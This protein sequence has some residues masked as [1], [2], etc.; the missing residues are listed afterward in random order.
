MDHY[1]LAQI[2]IEDENKYQKYIEKSEE[3]FNRYNGEYLA[4]DDHPI[5][6]EGTKQYYRTVLIKFKSKDDFFEWYHSNEYK[7]ILEYRLS[8]AH[9]NS[10]LIKG[11]NKK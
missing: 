5:V 9:C 7:Q 2:K 8:A 6:L 1:F 3:V 11:L 10:I 4:V